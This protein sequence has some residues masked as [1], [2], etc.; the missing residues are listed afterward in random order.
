[1]N[2]IDLIVIIVTSFFL[3]RGLF[4]GFILELTIVVGLIAG[5]ILA[6]S[7]HDL[8]AA[9]LFEYFPQLPESAANIISFA[10]IF[11]TVNIVLRIVAGIITKTIK[12]AMLGWLNRMLGALFGTIKSVV[13][14][15]IMVF[16]LN[17]IPF[18]E[19][20]LNK[21]GKDES[22]FFPMLETIGPEIY[23]QVEHTNPKKLLD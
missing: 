9:I 4:R 1:M 3:L 6:A 22:F 23:K 8:I 10:V 20:F 2:S 7:Y 17:L 13:I 18:S 16:I 14:L 21:A 12:F 19:S 11:I 15:S 5:Y